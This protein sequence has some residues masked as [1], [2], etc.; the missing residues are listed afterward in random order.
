MDLLQTLSCTHH[1]LEKA[2]FFTSSGRRLRAWDELLLASRKWFFCLGHK[3]Q[4]QQSVD[5]ITDFLDLLLV[6]AKFQMVPARLTDIAMLLAVSRKQMFWEMIHDPELKASKRNKKADANKE[7][8]AEEDNTSKSNA[9]TSESGETEISG[10]SGEQDEVESGSDEETGQGS[11]LHMRA[12]M[13]EEVTHVARSES[14]LR[15]KLLE[16]LQ[17]SIAPDLADRGIPEGLA[18]QVLARMT[19]EQLRQVTP[20]PNQIL[21]RVRL[22][23]FLIQSETMHDETM[24]FVSANR[25]AEDDQRVEVMTFMSYILRTM[26]DQESTLTWDHVKDVVDKFPVEDV[27]DLS[28]NKKQCIAVVQ[29]QRKHDESMNS[30]KKLDA[31]YEKMKKKRHEVDVTVEDLGDMVTSLQKTPTKDLQELCEFAQL[32]LDFLQMPSTKTW[33]DIALSSINEEDGPREMFGPKTYQAS[34]NEIACRVTQEETEQGT[35]V[36]SDEIVGSNA[37]DTNAEGEA[38]SLRRDDVAL[39]SQTPEQSTTEPTRAPTSPTWRAPRS[40]SADPHLADGRSTASRSQQG[41]LNLNDDQRRE[42]A[43]SHR[44]RRTRQSNAPTPILRAHE[45][46]QLKKLIG[47]I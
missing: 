33:E 39:L 47:D 16:Q 19:T 10:H 21:L 4:I 15:R 35:A 14:M 18:W 38:A 37:T 9:T 2:L 34:L 13:L 8:E 29:K 24:E 45:I 44:E 27:R 12:I 23:A 6:I 46:D 36:T 1:S 28:K 3:S 32:L 17:S 20:F 40:R 5:H 26:L 7:K 43:A 41:G 11:L 22:F 31:E 30:S 42:R 25:M